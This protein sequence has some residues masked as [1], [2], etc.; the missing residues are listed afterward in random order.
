MWDNGGGQGE[1]K[2]PSE[3][4]ATQGGVPVDLG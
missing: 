3:E 2:S 4:G 1:E